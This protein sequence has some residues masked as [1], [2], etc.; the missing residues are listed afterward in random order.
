MDAILRP[1]TPAR[2]PDYAPNLKNWSD[3]APKP[4]WIPRTLADT[5]KFIPRDASS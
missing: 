4:A 2:K 5:G 1:T 3:D